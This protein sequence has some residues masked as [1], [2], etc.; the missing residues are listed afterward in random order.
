[1][2]DLTCEQARALAAADPAAEQDAAQD[3]LLDFCLHAVR[4][5]DGP[6]ARRAPGGARHLGPAGTSSRMRSGSRDRRWCPL[7]PVPGRVSRQPDQGDHYHDGEAFEQQADGDG[8]HGGHV[9]VDQ[10]QVACAACVAIE[11]NICAR[12]DLAPPQ[13]ADTP[14]AAVV[15]GGAGDPACRRAGM[16]T[17][18]D[19]LVWAPAAFRKHGASTC[20]PGTWRLRERC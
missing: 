12:H 9:A 8:D 1:M 17:S 4:T 6:M 14:A 2:H 5:A 11:R 13:W 10:R 20:R 18:A 7:P 3:R 19:A 15:P 16:G